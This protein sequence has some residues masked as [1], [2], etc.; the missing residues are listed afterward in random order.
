MTPTSPAGIVADPTRRA[1]H[2]RRGGGGF[3][4]VE[5]I[6]VIAIIV[7]LM[8]LALPSVNTMWE[9]RKLA[10]AKNTIQGMLQTARARAM[11]ASGLESGMFFFLDRNGM[12]Y[13]IPIELDPA[14]S[15]DVAWENVF[16]VRYDRAYTL[17]PPFRVVPRYVVLEAGSDAEIFSVGELVNNSF[18]TLEAAANNAQR[19]RNFFAM[20]FSS[21]GQLLVRR[22][23]LIQDP[24][25]DEDGYGDMTRL[26][27][28]P[29]PEA[30]GSTPAVNSYYAQND[31]ITPMQDDDLGVP[32]TIAFL[33]RDADE[34]EAAVNFPSVDGL[35]VYDD[36][37]FSGLSPPEQ[38]RAYLLE[39]AQP[40]YVNRF[41][42]AIIKGPRGEN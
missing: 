21:E 16:R 22:D 18:A 42:G 1:G 19:H 3:T 7:V 24:D 38:Q 40:Y 2:R 27:V 20:V 14:R 25:E 28:G 32:T 30:G 35:L 39:A 8:A 34:D 23:V 5:M 15:G 26:A 11:S 17:P 29:D 31:T 37:L 13:I 10:A 4:L 6:V 12:Q 33:V 9:E 41:T 36:S